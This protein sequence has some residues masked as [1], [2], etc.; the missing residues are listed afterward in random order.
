MIASYTFSALLT[1]CQ[2]DLPNI[3]T[4]GIL[5]WVPMRKSNTC[6]GYPMSYA[7]YV[8]IFQPYDLYA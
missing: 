1:N 4:P 5:R 2:G 7:R 6:R 3:L 8:E